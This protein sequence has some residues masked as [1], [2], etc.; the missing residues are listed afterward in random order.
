MSSLSTLKKEITDSYKKAKNENA[1][2]V[3]EYLKSLNE[4]YNKQLEAY[5]KQ[6]AAQKAAVPR[7][8][9]DDYDLNAINRLINERKLNERMSSLG[10]T[11]SGA[12]ATLQAGLDVA[13]QNADNLVTV[14]KKKELSNLTQAYNNYYNE[15]EA[16]LNSKRDAAMKALNDKYASLLSTLT[17]KYNDA[18]KSS[19]TAN[20]VGSNSSTNLINVYNKLLSMSSPKQ[21]IFYIDV[22]YDDGIL[23]GSQVSRLKQRLGLNNYY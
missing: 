13:K 9:T 7:N 20:T 2:A 4:S 19:S 18:V 22:L 1:K 14:Q 12:N 21:Q 6:I 15:L 5:T 3:N 8:Y 23:T 17:S 11:K 16:D 10:L